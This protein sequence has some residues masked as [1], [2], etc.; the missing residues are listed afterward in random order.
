MN[1]DEAI[2][3]IINSIEDSKY[4]WRTIT[5][6]VSETHI[7]RN[8]VYSFLIESNE[9]IKARNLNKQ[10]HEL[11]TTRKKQKKESSVGQLILSRLLNRASLE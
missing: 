10:G 3:K 9:I 2:K 5:G 6:I 1:S 7:P 8:K 11:F 4:K